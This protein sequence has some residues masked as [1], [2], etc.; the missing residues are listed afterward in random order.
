[1][2]AVYVFQAFE[3][4]FNKQNF[5]MLRKSRN[6]IEDGLDRFKNIQNEKEIK[7]IQNM[8]DIFRLTRNAFAHDPVHPKWIIN[9]KEKSKCIDIDNKIQ[10]NLVNLDGKAIELGHFDGAFGLLYLLDTLLTKIKNL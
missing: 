1:M 6:L 5:P 9:R 4:F 10:F 7:A 8:I 2:I 3:N